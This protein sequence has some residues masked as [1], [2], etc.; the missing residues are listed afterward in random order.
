MLG[1][2]EHEAHERGDGKFGERAAAEGE[3]EGD[4]GDVEDR[5]GAAVAAGAEV[6]DG[7][8]EEAAA[9]HAAAEARE[10]VAG[11][12]R[13]A[14][15]GRVAAAVGPVAREAVDE[16][17]RQEAL[18]EADGGELECA[19]HRR[20]DD[21]ERRPRAEEAAARGGRR[22]G[23][24]RRGQR[25]PAALEGPD[26]VPEQG[27]GHRAGARERGAEAHGQER[28][29]RVARDRGRRGLDDDERRDREEG[30]APQSRAAQPD[31]LRVLE[32]VDLGPQDLDGESVHEAEDDGLRHHADEA[33]ALEEAD[34]E[35]QGARERDGDAHRLDA[36]GRDEGPEHE[37]TRR[38]RARDHAGPP[39]EDRRR[40]ADDERRPE[41]D[42]RVRARDQR[43]LRRLGDDGDGRREA[44]EAVGAQAAEARPGPAPRVL[45]AQKQVHDLEH[46]RVDPLRHAP[47]RLAPGLAPP[48]LLPQA[49][50]ARHGDAQPRDDDDKKDRDATHRGARR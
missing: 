22:E 44:R 10:D 13:A 23:E 24:E 20:R 9:A 17:Q 12:E 50:Q 28:R 38:G 33:A 49:R 25:P 42:E 37:R 27:H 41:A 15:L 5:G 32:V 43:E 39:P 48:S 45:Q 6:D 19:G 4:E 2:G 36:V 46:G 18:E 11:A 26:D 30:V 14:F 7:L 34:E 8:A 3:R 16:L 31:A 47:R 35:L 1:D 21:G 29:G 40:R